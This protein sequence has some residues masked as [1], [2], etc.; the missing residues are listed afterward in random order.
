MTAVE[1]LEELLRGSEEMTGFDD[2]LWQEVV[3]RDAPQCGKALAGAR[4]RVRRAHDALLRRMLNDGLLG[5]A[6]LTFTSYEAETEAPAEDEPPAPVVHG[7]PII[8]PR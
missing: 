2:S 7:P 1:Y 3:C 8:P 5:G 4:D 6:K